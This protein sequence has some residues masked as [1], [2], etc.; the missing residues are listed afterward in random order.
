MQDHKGNWMTFDHWNREGRV[1]V[2]DKV[3]NTNRI[4]LQ[5]H[6][7]RIKYRIW[8]DIKEM[9]MKYTRDASRE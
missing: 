8:A 7:E 3:V 4:S 2:S 6:P 1:A 9:A 5:L